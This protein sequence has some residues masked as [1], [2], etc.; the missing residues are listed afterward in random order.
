M[1]LIHE[2]F[3]W[4][5]FLWGTLVRAN[6]MTQSPYF[7]LHYFASVIIVFCACILIDQLRKGIFLL[8]KIIIQRAKMKRQQ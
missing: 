4:R 1:Y 6:K 8:V 2:N 3:L 5:E 7:I